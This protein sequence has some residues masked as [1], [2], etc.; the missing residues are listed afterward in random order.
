MAE[1][2]KE[3]FDLNL[4][5]QQL[6]AAQSIIEQNR[7]PG[8]AIR[9]SQIGQS[10][11]E[12]EQED[13]RNKENWDFGSLVAEGQSILSGGLQDTASSVAT[14]PERAVDMFSGEMEAENKTEEGYRPEWDPFTDYDNP[15]ETKTW[16]GKL[17]RGAVHF[18]SLAVGTV[19]AAK[20]AGITAPAWL[21]GMGGYSLIRAAGIG[22]VSDL[23]SRESDG[24]NALGVLRDKYSWIDTPIST[25]DTD[26]PAWMKFKNIVEG[27]GIGLAFDGLSIALGKGSK[28]VMNRVRARN[29]SQKA[30]TIEEALAQ[31]RRED[32][33]VYRAAKNKPISEPH[34][35]ANIS[36]DERAFQVRERLVRGRKEW[37]ADDGSA[38]NFTTGAERERIAKNASLAPDLVEKT[39][40]DLWSDSQY[41]AELEAVRSQGLSLAEVYGDAVSKH[42][43]IINGR[44]PLD[45]SPEEYLKTAIERKDL[46]N[47]G[48]EGSD[49]DTIEILTTSNVIT[50]DL[51]VAT[52]LQQ[53]RDLGIAGREL[54]DIV[55]LLEKDGPAKK[56]V[57]TILTALSLTKRARLVKSRNLSGLKAGVEDTVTQG[58]R[59]LDEVVNSDMAD[60][61]ESIASML[62]LAGTDPD[63]NL[64]NAMFEA[65][66]M[67]DNLHTLD[68][69]D[70]WAR[71]MIKG[72]EFKGRNR[73]GA[74]IRE[75][76]G[77]MVQSVLSGPKTPLRAV[78]GTST[79][80]FMRP[81]AT[82]V[83]ASLRYPWEK[84]TA[85]IRSGLA[86]MN[87]M[88]EAIPE[89]FELFKTRLNSYWSGEISTVKT[90]F[91]EYTKGDANWEV[92]RRWA[93]DSG[94]ATVGE[95]AAFRLAN[96]ARM[97][98]ILLS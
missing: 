44:S 73:T 48:P 26:H 15:I 18:G 41:Q 67:I 90:R 54:K 91:S 80:T 84:D 45:M 37:L 25:K 56:I 63:N 10:Q 39:L 22:A 98:N 6:G 95:T 17:L 55:N 86:S 24:H 53:V 7:N 30:Q 9:Q 3:G 21:S 14:F 81:M 59:Y 32:A 8:E 42:H 4:L 50:L 47:V 34:Q 29:N 52:L 96:L 85:T 87:A 13:P 2:P 72:G 65:F 36:T 77:V 93:E 92:L 70:V 62:H 75:L 43:E 19:V 35:G 74:A 64:L 69:F 51:T 79:A 57:D 28:T 49:A 88:M 38:G 78:M 5:Q 27:M 60:T 76:E 23:I 33:A 11:E 20:A 82:F 97:A 40:K 61:R 12:Q 58:R 1:D 89:S 66:S 68:D 83:G 71:K 16:W 46:I 31:V 94:R